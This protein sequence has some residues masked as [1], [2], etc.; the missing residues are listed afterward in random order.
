M[1]FAIY[2]GTFYPHCDISRGTHAILTWRHTL[3][4]CMKINTKHQLCTVNYL[5]L[6]TLAAERT[7]IN[8]LDNHSLIQKSIKIHENL[9]QLGGSFLDADQHLH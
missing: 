3:Y 5:I 8:N 6:Y 2:L 1:Q 9:V 4:K 7:K